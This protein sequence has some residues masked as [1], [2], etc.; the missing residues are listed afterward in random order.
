MARERELAGLRRHLDEALAGRGGQV[1]FIAGEAGSG[2]TALLQEF[3]RQ[4]Q[5]ARP[6]LVVTAGSCNAWTGQGDP[7]LPFREVLELL[8]GHVESCWASG[9]VPPESLRRLL[10]LRPAA[11][12]TLVNAGPGLVD[13]FIPGTLLLDQAVS[14][15]ISPA[16]T[17]RLKQLVERRD[18]DSAGRGNQQAL[19]EELAQVLNTLARQQPLL[20]LLDD[21]HWA[22]AASI[23][24]LFHLSRRLEGSRILLVLSYRPDEVAMGRAG[25]RHPL[26]P[27]FNE[28]K[29]RYGDVE[30]D[31]GQAMEPHFIETLL[32]TEPNRLGPE[33]RAALYHRTRGHPLFTVELL[34][35]MQER[36][37]LVRDE[38]GRW[39]EG[40]A[41]DWARLPARIEAVIAE[42]IG[43]LE[44]G[45]R[46]LLS[47]ASVEGETFTAQVAARVLELPERQALRL[48]SQELEKRHFLVQ[49][50]GEITAGEARLSRY[51]F[52]HLLIQEYLYQELSAGER[53]LL[54]GEVAA[55]LEALYGGQVEEI[56]VALGRHY[57]EAGQAEKAVDYLLLA[58]DKARN[59]YAHAEAI[60]F[61]RQA[62]NFLKEQGLAGRERAARTLMKLGLTYHF[63]FDFKQ[64]RQ[65]YEEGFA[66]W[67]WT[68]PQPVTGLPAAPHPLRLA[69]SS[70]PTM[71]PGMAGDGGS[72]N[73]IAQVFSGLMALRPEMEVV[74]ELAR[75]W[76]VL[77]GGREYVFRLRD[78]VTWSD[79]RPV[80]AEDFVYAW[81]RTL[82]PITRSPAA[83]LLYDLKGARAFHRGEIN[84]P[85]AVGVRAPDPLTLL[86]ELERPTGYFP[87]LMANNLTYPLPRHVVEL[88]GPAWTEPEHIV[89]NG[90]FNIQTWRPGE[91][92]RLT[93]NPAYRGEFGG[94]V[95]ELE[96]RY[97]V[98][99]TVEL[100]AYEEDRLDVLDL[101]HLLSA[102][103]RDWARSRHAGE[104]VVGPGLDTMYLGFDASR[105]PFDD[106]RVRRAFALATDR[107]TLASLVM[108]GYAAPAL[109]GF[110]PPGLPGHSPDIGLPYDPEQARRLL[111]EAG[112]PG[113]QGFPA[114]EWLIKTKDQTEAEYLQAQ[115]RENLGMDLSWQA[116]ARE[117]LLQR[118]SQ[119][120]PQLFLMGWI[121][122]Y[123]DSDNFLRVSWQHTRVGWQN[124]T[125]TALVEQARAT[126]DMSERLALH[127]QADRLLMQEAAIV[128]L[129]YMRQQLLVKPWV[130]K[131]PISVMRSWFFKD[132]VIEP[133]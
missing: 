40:P 76:E 133:H 102:Q 96:L 59:L 120:S 94:N 27:V 32:E 70:P 48:L 65:S 88:Y 31:L 23:G 10:H 126:V 105:P 66:L 41:L 34:R 117:C 101:G 100:Q 67:Q 128:P 20:L 9:L 1:V 63:A 131:Y 3:A 89:T 61:Y 51:G 26:E 81:R 73:H 13:S 87:Q 16:V 42:R 18:N 127:R 95:Q 44:P 47:I 103:E 104:Y 112:F 60:N 2:K 125:Y 130:R 58:G 78:D 11:L 5:A 22:D 82:H 29:R 113:G 12:Q 15:G 49:E 74:P 84:D 121:A 77:G 7:Y 6:D 109:G 107:E 4:A 116:V 36:G 99:R 64:A 110:V 37:D 52:T 30:L 129:A 91:W 46:E 83:G 39:V 85:A 72:V 17:A 54:H 93:R 79:G 50:R 14:P 25:E 106:A 124:E 57:G 56:V 114:V 119:D 68:G 111:A 86:V 118:T 97:D 123:F 80:T 28:L 33:F 71:D 90:P 8:I 19:F 92:M 108:G 115:W 69:R 24:L 122:D 45:Q 35:A 132:V 62:L 55:A 98:A 75:S 43:R 21:F 38:L 53:R